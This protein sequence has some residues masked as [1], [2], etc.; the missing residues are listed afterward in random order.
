MVGV[1]YHLI[2]VN[3]KPSGF[4]IAGVEVLSPHWAKYS[5]FQPRPGHFSGTHFLWCSAH[6]DHAL[7]SHRR[8][9][10]GCQHQDACWRHAEWARTPPAIPRSARDQ[11]ASGILGA[12]AH[13]ATRAM[14]WTQQKACWTLPNVS[15]SESLPGSGSGR[16]P[17]RSS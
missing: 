5:A 2:L 7:A 9:S 4:W 8:V 16:P 12:D 1:S 14:P 3:R 6:G 17:C 10:R 13:A 11:L 15:P